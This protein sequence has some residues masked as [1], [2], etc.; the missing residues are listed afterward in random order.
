MSQA[1]FDQESVRR[2]R[3]RS[4]PLPLRACTALGTLVA[5]A[6]LVF[7]AANARPAPSIQL[8]AGPGTTISILNSRE[9]LAVLAAG[10]L[11]PGDTTTGSV[12]ITNTGDGDGAFSLSKSALNDVAGSGAGILSSKLDLTITDTTIP[13]SPVTV[14]SGKVSGLGVVALGT[15][16]AG[17]ARTYD[18]GVHFPNGATGA[19]NAYQGASMSVTLDWDAVLVGG[20]P[21]PAVVSATP[22]DGTTTASATS[23]A[24]TTN[25]ALATVQG[26]TLDG[27]AVAT[28]LAGTQL[29][30]TTGALA[31]GPHT[32]AGVLEGIDGQTTPFRLHFTV[33]SGPATDYPYVEMNSPAGEQIELTSTDGGARL[34]VPANAWSGASTGDWAVFRVDPAAAP[35][36]AG[37][38]A[39]STDLYAVTGYWALAPGDLNTFDQALDLRIDSGSGPVVPAAYAAGS[40][41]R[42]QA[43]PSGTSLPAGWDDGY[44]TSGGQVHVLTMK[45]GAFGL[46]HDVQA[47]TKPKAFRSTHKRGSA[48]L[49]WRAAS[50]NEGVAGYLVYR[51]SA[52]V[53]TLPASA[54]SYVAGRVKAS[55][56]RT[57]ALAARDAAGNVGRRT[58][59]L[60]TVPALVNL[61]LARAKAALKHR[62][63]KAGAITSGYSATIRAGHVIRAGRSGV[64]AKGTAVA[65]VVSKGP[66]PRSSGSSGPLGSGENGGTYM[67]TPT[68]YTPPPVNPA[69][70]PPPVSP[71][72][73][74]QPPTGPPLYQQTSGDGGPDGLP[75][76]RR[77]D[78]VAGSNPQSY[79][80]SDRSGGRK[81][82]G[83]ALL[84]GLFLGAGGLAFHARRGISHRPPATAA[85][86]GQLLFWDERLLRA[87][88]SAFRRVAGVAGR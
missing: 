41:R 28:T 85:A 16:A 60:V 15:Y 35:A 47:P 2:Q 58:G 24:L 62:G 88:M 51:G 31:S 17:E 80:E 10:N 12:T 5:V 74:V 72:P 57:F 61:T 68:T 67:P 66:H 44:Y 9:G 37:G 29:T 52:V 11:R 87:T 30:F 49:R 36:A 82:L 18:F 14:Y 40:W 46:L 22:T 13:A 42:L 26:A 21:A 84:G 3:R 6:A 39:G 53:K 65:L 63:L 8:A 25:V 27:G 1:T 77:A 73:A 19:E 83:L 4:V 70:T 78:Q 48:I 43:I 7:T 75:Q 56:K 33:W 55:D 79:T 86:S 76:T 45:P 81:A 50:D 71:P 38:L 32:V 54:R 59:S 69:T 34:T 64:V 20:A 23:A